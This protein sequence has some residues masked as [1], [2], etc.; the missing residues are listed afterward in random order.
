MAH[1]S[2]PLRAGEGNR[3]PVPSLGSSCSTTELHPQVVRLYQA[4]MACLGEDGHGSPYGHNHTDTHQEP[5]AARPEF[6]FNTGRLFAPSILPHGQAV[7]DQQGEPYSENQ[8][9]ENLVDP[10][11]VTHEI[12]NRSPVSLPKGIQRGVIVSRPCH[13][14][15][16]FTRGENGGNHL[17][18]VIESEGLRTVEMQAIATELGFSETIFF[19]PAAI[20]EV[21]IFTPGREMPFAGHPLVGMTWVLH[22]SGISTTDR[23][24][25]GIG[26]VRVGYADGIAWIE[27]SP[28]RSVREVADAERFA[29]ILG[30]A[31]PLN[32]GWV[33]MP[34]PYLLLELPSPTHVATASFDERALEEIGVGELYLYAEVDGQRVKAR[35]FAPEAGVFE[36]PATGSAAVALASKLAHD[37][38]AS[39]SLE[40]DQGDEMGHPSTIQLDWNHDGIRIGGTVR[41]DGVRLLDG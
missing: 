37:G 22:E 8:L 36:D 33:D 35:F 27:A 19:A 1:G 13:V 7:A 15:R 5:G 29:A 3:T 28:D 16:V 20:P 17:G 12:D 30:I 18:V 24:A 31:T 10:N 23:L 14:V 4:R 39:G 2:W 26:E 6:A 34:I 11:D 9:R 40:I 41:A 25:C 21:R 38:R 32:A